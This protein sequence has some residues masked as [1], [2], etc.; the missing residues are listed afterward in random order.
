[1]KDL[2]VIITPAIKHLK[3]CHSGDP[4]I[5]VRGRRRNPGGYWMPVGDPLFSGDQ[6]RHD[7]ISIVNRRVNNMKNHLYWVGT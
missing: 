3:Y 4:R 1:M 7:G 6:V 5:R 2:T